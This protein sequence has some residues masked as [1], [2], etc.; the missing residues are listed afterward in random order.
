MIE[1]GRIILH[2]MYF[3]V[4]LTGKMKYLITN[5]YML[6]NPNYCVSSLLSK[7]ALKCISLKTHDIAL[8]QAH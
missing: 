7:C 6:Y 3:N 1:S 5:N 2:V 8:I 4:H